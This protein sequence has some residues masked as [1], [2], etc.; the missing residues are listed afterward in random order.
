MTMQARQGVPA[1]CAR[2]IR[3]TK[4]SPIPFSIVTESTTVEVMKN[5]DMRGNGSQRFSSIML[6]KKTRF[7]SNGPG[8]RYTR[9]APRVG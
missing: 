5:C 7:E 1:L 4:A 3:S 8:F 6:L 9:N 2:M